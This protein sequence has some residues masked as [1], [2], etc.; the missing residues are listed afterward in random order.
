MNLN[1]VKKRYFIVL[2]RSYLLSLQHEL[3]NRQAPRIYTKRGI[4]PTRR[5]LELEKR[6]KPLRAIISRGGRQGTNFSALRYIRPHA[7]ASVLHSGIH[8][9]QL[10]LRLPVLTLLHSYL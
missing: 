3:L 4:R 5:R 2:Y 6:A 7:W 9:P 8:H 1:M 10:Y